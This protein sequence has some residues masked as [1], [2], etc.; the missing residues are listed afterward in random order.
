MTAKLHRSLLSTARLNKAEFSCSQP[1]QHL[2]SKSRLYPWIQF[3]MH[4]QR[5]KEWHQG[6][7]QEWMSCFFSVRRN[8]PVISSQISA[9]NAINFLLQLQNHFIINRLKSL[10]NISPHQ[11]LPSNRQCRRPSGDDRNPRLTHLILGRSRRLWPDYGRALATIQHCFV[12][13]LVH[14]KQN[15]EQELNSFKCQG[16]SILIEW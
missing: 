11:W 9:R 2:V 6:Q 8:Y 13:A 14:E 15:T 4:W 3:K 7:R 1:E 16:V 10:T 5:R 12:L